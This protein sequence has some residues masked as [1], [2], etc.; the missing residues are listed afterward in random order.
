M[1][2]PTTDEDHLIH[3]H[4]DPDNA[5]GN[6]GKEPAEM[7]EYYVKLVSAYPIIS[8]EDGMAED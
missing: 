8:I 6:S 7:V 1:R 4:I 2:D 3:H 5:A